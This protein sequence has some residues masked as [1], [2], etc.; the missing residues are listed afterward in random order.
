MSQP[1]TSA[2]PP[3]PASS[4]DSWSPGD[5]SLTLGKHVPGPGANRALPLEFVAL[6][7]PS[8][9]LFTLLPRPSCIH[10]VLGS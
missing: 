9:V 6:P 2:T 10:T 3:C 1:P 7:W 8:W 5:S 4:P